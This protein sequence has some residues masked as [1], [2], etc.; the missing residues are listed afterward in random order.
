MAQRVD[1]QDCFSMI[2]VGG[3]NQEYHTFVSD[4]WEEKI[5]GSPAFQ[6]CEKLKGT[7]TRLHDWKKNLGTNSQRRITKIRDEIRRG[8]VDGLMP[9]ERFRAKEKELKVALNKEEKYWKVK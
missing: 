5:D 2:H 9:H 7:R 3:Q 4:S 8:I 6:I 1:R